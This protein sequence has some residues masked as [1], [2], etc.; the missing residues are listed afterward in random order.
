MVF[1]AF[2]KLMGKPQSI[3]GFKQFEKAIHLNEEFFR[4][5]TGIAELGIALLILIFAFSKNSLTGK[6]AYLFLLITMLS[7]L[8]LEFF[9]RPEPKYMLVVIAIFLSLVAMYKLRK[10]QSS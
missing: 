3:A 1:F 6:F 10:L 8:M 7:G 5:F 9:A 4:I 2:P